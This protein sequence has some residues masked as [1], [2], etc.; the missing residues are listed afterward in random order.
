MKLPRIALAVSA[1]LALAT[2]SARAL[3]YWWERDL[4]FANKL[5]VPT[6]KYFDLAEFVLTKL[7][8]NPD[9]IGI[10]KAKLL[11]RI[12]DYYADKADDVAKGPKWREK[13]VDYINKSRAYYQKFLDQDATKTNPKLAEEAFRV[14]TRVSWLSLSLAEGEAKALEAPDLSKEEKEKAKP[15]VVKLFDAAIEQFKKAIPEKEREATEFNKSEPKDPKLREAWSLKR[16]A[17]RAEVFMVSHLYSQARL[18]LAKFLRDTKSPEPEVDGLLKAIEKDLIAIRLNPMFNTLPAVLPNANLTLC[19]CLFDQGPA[20]DKDLDER[21]EDIWGARLNYAVKRLPCDAQFLRTKLYMRQK[22]LKEAL[23][24]DDELL[25]YRTGVWGAEAKGPQAAQAVREILDNFAGAPADDYD[26]RSIAGAILLEA[27]IFAGLGQQAAKEGKPPKTVEKLYA[28][29]HN[30]AEGVRLAKVP[31]DRKYGALIETWREKAKLPL[32]I[33]DRLIELDRAITAKEYGKAAVT[34]S[35]LIRDGGYPREKLYDCWMMVGNLY[36]NSK[37]FYEGYTAFWGAARWFPNRDVDS[38]C[39]LTLTCLKKAK[40]E[41]K[42][43]ETE[44]FHT[45]LYE[46]GVRDVVALRSIETALPIIDAKTLRAQGHLDEAVKKLKEILPDTKY[47]AEALFET[48]QTRRLMAEKAYREDKKGDAAKAAAKACDDAFEALDAYYQKKLPTLANDEEKADERKRLIQTA[49]IGLIARSTALL[50]DFL[51]RPAK[52]LELTATGLEK[53]YAGIEPTPYY[54]LALFYRIRAAYFLT[55]ADPDHADPNLTILEDSW[56]TLREKVKD[57]QY[58]DKAAATGAGAYGLVAE[59]LDTLLKTAQDP[60]EL[61]KVNDPELRKRL[62]DPAEVKK[63]ADRVTVVKNRALEFYFQL[64]DANPKQPLNTYRFIVM[65]L[66]TRDVAPRSN[67]FRKITKMAPDII[68]EIKGENDPAL[69]AIA[70]QLKAVLGISHAQLNQFA[71]AIPILEE[72]D[73]GY[74]KNYQEA[75]KRWTKF[76][77]QKEEHEAKKDPRAARMKVPDQPARPAFQPDVKYWLGRSYLGGAVRDKYPTAVKLFTQLITISAA[78]SNLPKYWEAFY[79]YCE[80]NAKMGN[81]GDAVGQINRAV[82]RDPNL[83][84]KENKARFIQFLSRIR[85]DVEKN[86][87]PKQPGL[88]GQLD[89]IVKTLGK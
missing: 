64:L 66:Y 17:L 57:F 34:M 40:D 11:H 4:E 52:V 55:K 85:P 15:N 18:R 23:Q 84:S 69:I 31:M 54:G 72:V 30:Q 88:L 56:K 79:W 42:G 5:A 46:R 86:P 89:E 47:Y 41:S 78:S 36:F 87:D 65:S 21:I 71:E 22:K 27:E 39:R 62:A 9:I 20:R 29:A 6:R 19:H 26:P 76:K 43:T 74:E 25:K 59:R 38:A 61:A 58:L 33:S 60:A 2:S 83:Y 75:M 44:A 1:L 37:R 82:L 32:S 28:T 70:N 10:Q 3:E 45:A 77:E 12:G 49:T 14:R 67:D 24:A 50:E 35:D 53:R 8:N 16:D 13:M 81:Y 80:A 51:G 73:A 7:E 63:I 68:E 48:A